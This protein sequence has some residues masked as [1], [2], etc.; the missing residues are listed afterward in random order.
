MEFAILGID[1]NLQVFQGPILE[2]LPHISFLR[3]L[4]HLVSTTNSVLETNN[5]RKSTFIIEIS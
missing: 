3:G 2:K 1:H 5:D 4:Q